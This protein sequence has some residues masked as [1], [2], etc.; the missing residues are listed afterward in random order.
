M[1]DLKT[2]VYLSELAGRLELGLWILI[3][4]KDLYIR[5]TNP[6]LNGVNKS[7]SLHTKLPP[8]KTVHNTWLESNGSKYN[9]NIVFTVQKYSMFLTAPLRK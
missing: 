3:F 9:K 8:A 1:L 4:W 6:T 7:N 2:N 5:Y